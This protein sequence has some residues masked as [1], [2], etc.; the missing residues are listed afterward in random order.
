LSKY[1]VKY[2]DRTASID[3]AARIAVGAT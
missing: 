1:G 3:D 2:L